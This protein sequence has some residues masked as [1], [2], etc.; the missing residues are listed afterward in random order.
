MLWPALRSRMRSGGRPMSKPCAGA[1]APSRPGQLLPVEP[2]LA[3]A[4]GGPLILI[5]LTIC[6][7]VF[8][9]AAA[10]TAT[11]GHAIAQTAPLSMTEIA[12]GVFVHNGVHEEASSGNKDAIANIGFI[13][14]ADAVAVIDPGGS[15]EEGA[16]LREAIRTR[17]DRPIRYV[18]LTHVH[19][20]HIF[21]A[22]AFRDDRPAFVSHAKLAGALAQRGEYYLRRLHSSLGEEAKGSEIVPP[23]L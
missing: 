15:F 20:D 1:R 12:S 18:I 22:A 17:T 21:G 9:I 8:G 5:R 6:L 3:P 16:A 23:T 2:T 10:L 13:V 11:P 19:P 7:A 4:G 14:G